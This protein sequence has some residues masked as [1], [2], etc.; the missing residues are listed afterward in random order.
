MKLRAWE[1]WRPPSSAPLE[2]G[3]A[4]E[5]SPSWLCLPQGLKQARAP[6]RALC[7]LEL[8]STCPSSAWHGLGTG[9]APRRLFRGAHAVLGRQGNRGKESAVTQSC[10]AP[11]WSTAPS[12]FCGLAGMRPPE[13]TYTHLKLSLFCK[14][15]FIS[16][17]EVRLCLAWI[18]RPELLPPPSWAAL[19][20]CPRH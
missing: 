6:Q 1:P 15:L 13:T 7:W 19:S 11:V 18:W 8:R 2:A 3:M 17:G 20:P 9:S 10:L 16:A 12:W 5:L 4:A 14:A